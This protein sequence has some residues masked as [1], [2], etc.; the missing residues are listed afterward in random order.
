MIVGGILANIAALNATI[1]SS[2]RVLFAMGREK[3]VWE[4]LGEMHEINRTPY[5]ALLLS[6]LIIIFVLLFLP[7]KDIAGAADFLF[8][9]LFIQLNLAYIQLRRKIPEARWEYTVPFGIWLPLAAIALYVILG[10]S[11]F[12]VSPIGIY[13]TIFWL[14]SGLVNYF[15]YTKKEEREDVEREII[16]EHTTRFR[17]KSGYRV[18]LPIAEEE[19]LQEFSQIAFA[20][21]KE[22][23]GDILALRVSEV[24]PSLPLNA[25]FHSDHEQRLLDKVE[26]AAVSQKLNVDT[27]LVVARSIPDAILENVEVENGD[28]L[29]MG[30]DGYVNSKGFIFGRKVDVVLHRVKCDLMVV[31]LRD[32]REIKQILVPVAIDENPNLR[33]TGKVATALSKWFG[34][35]V[36]IMMIIPEKVVNLEYARYFAILEDRVRELKLKTVKEPKIKL[37]R[38]NY[39]ASAIIKEAIHYDLVLLPAARDRITQAIGVGSIPEQ[40]V[41]HCQKTVIIAKGHRGIIQPFLDY[42]RS[43]F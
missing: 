28:L 10:V 32:L 7:L 33:F 3:F 38:S 22:E 12:H 27:R 30:W 36:T 11:L 34:G 2:S 43:R 9:A 5:R 37:V 15:A 4:K 1:Y 39:I 40:V 25:G 31:K 8:I 24:A 14:L 20:L 6:T 41:K 16:Y 23:G 21:A 19:D 26:K 18:I 17:E 13:F 29:V 35:E 42:L